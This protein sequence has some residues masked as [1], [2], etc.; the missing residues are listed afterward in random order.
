MPDNS[1]LE[2]FDKRLKRIEK[3]IT[4]NEK[5]IENLKKKVNSIDVESARQRERRRRPY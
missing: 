2:D 5:D 4:R 3:R 1:Q